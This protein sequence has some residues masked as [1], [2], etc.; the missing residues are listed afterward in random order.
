MSATAETV[1][2]QFQKLPR[3][4]QQEVYEQ[5]LRLLQP[6]PRKSERRFPTV[7]VTG[8]AITSR[9]VIEALDDE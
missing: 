5:L 2:E 7:E 3:S 4:E 8:G 6:K 9:Q 1:L